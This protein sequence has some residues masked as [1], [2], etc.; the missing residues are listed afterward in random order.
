MTGMFVFDVEGKIAFVGPCFTYPL[1][2]RISQLHLIFVDHGS[3]QSLTRF[4]FH[5]L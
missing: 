1:S 3:G 2:E 5:F 4:Y